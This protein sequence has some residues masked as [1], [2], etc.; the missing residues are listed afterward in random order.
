MLTS[1]ALDSSD[2]KQFAEYTAPDATVRNPVSPTRRVRAVL[3]DVDGTLY[4]QRP[5]RLRMA[6]ELG[7]LALTRPLRAPAIWRTL[8]AYRRA[9]ERLR[10]GEGADAARQLELAAS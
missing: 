2:V 10:S 3:F 6:A 8:S 7:G 9:Q 5:L 4:R 1:Q